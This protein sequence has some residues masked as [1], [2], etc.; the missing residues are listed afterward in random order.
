MTTE[1]I[2]KPRVGG[3]GSGYDSDWKV[4]VVND[5]HNSFDHVIETFCRVLP[6][7]DPERALCLAV[8]IHKTGRGIVWMGMREHAEM[9][10]EQLA[11]AGLRVAPLER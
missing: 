8:N 9:Y 11:H 10:A 6:S 1:I 4:I 3:P 5:D 7:M 2:E